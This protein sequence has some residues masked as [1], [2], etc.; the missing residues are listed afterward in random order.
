MFKVSK[1]RF[2]LPERRKY[3]K[4]TIKAQGLPEK[5]TDSSIAQRVFNVYHHQSIWEKMQLQQMKSPPD[6]Q[7]D[8]LAWME[9]GEACKKSAASLFVPCVIQAV[10]EAII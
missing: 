4:M 1:N 2:L 9:G 8:K 6:S 7:T 3:D 5:H 10:V